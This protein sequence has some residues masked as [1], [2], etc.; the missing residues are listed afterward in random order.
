MK[1][2]RRRYGSL[3]EFGRLGIEFQFQT[4]GL[5]N[6]ILSGGMT[7]NDALVLTFRA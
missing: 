5:E 3:R 7:L 2:E 4:A 6:E 1:W